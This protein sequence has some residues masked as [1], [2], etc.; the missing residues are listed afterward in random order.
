MASNSQNMKSFYPE[1]KPTTAKKSSKKSPS[2]A[3]TLGS[4]AA[5]TPALVSDAGKPDLKDEYDEKETL[6][7]QFDLNIAY[8]PCVGITR[9]ARWERA[10]R[11]GLN[12][13]PEIQSLLKSGNVQTESLWGDRI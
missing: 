9:L 8:G 5:Q 6:L 7:R 1:K 12:P 3:A 4:T 10:Q 11:F 13:P 2:N